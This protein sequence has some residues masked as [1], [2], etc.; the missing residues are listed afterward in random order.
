MPQLSEP[1]REKLSK[2]VQEVGT[3][4]AN[5]I[6][7]TGLFMSPVAVKTLFETLK[8]ESKVDSIIFELA[9]QYPSFYADFIDDPTLSAAL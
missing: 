9:V 4:V 2:A 1:S 5:P 3:S 7:L 6:D 8:E